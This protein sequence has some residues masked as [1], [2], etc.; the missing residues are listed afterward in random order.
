MVLGGY[1]P[2]QT[3]NPVA[4]HSGGP[5]DAP[6]FF[7][8]GGPLSRFANRIPGMNAIAGMHDVFV[9]Q[10][11]GVVRFVLNVPLMIPAAGITV[12][13][14]AASPGIQVAYDAYDAAKS[15]T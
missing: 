1:Q 6:G 7:A 12:A 4:R 13:A 14:L 2:E 3:A 8:E 11:A 5:V 9:T 10:F 15:G